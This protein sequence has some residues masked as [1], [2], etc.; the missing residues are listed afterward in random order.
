MGNGNNRSHIF[1]AIISGM[2]HALS[3]FARREH[4]AAFIDVISRQ[5]EDVPVVI[6]GNSIHLIKTKAP[7]IFRKTD[8]RI[9]GDRFT[10]VHRPERVNQCTSPYDPPENVPHFESLE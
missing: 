5:S 8:F 7:A 9:I 2:L 10:S 4:F 1:G 6:A 3:L